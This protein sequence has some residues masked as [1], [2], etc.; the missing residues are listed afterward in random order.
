MLD[1]ADTTLVIKRIGMLYGPVV[2]G[3]AIEMLD[4]NFGKSK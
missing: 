1:A 3:P 4:P 2:V